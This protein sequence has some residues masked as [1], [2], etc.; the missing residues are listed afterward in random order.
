MVLLPDGPLTTDDIKMLQSSMAMVRGLKGVYVEI[1]SLAG[2]SSVVIGIEAKAQKSRLYCIDVWNSGKWESVAA[3]IGSAAGNYPKRPSNIY[4]QFC[5][6]IRVNYLTD[7]VL[8][9]IERSDVAFKTWSL[10]VRFIF[11]D[12]CHEYGF[13]KKD[14]M[15]GRFLTTGGVI[16][17]HDYHA[18]WPG[19]I[20]AV[21]EVYT[22]NIY[23]QEVLRGVQTIA[24]K[25]VG[26]EGEK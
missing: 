5:D 9:I 10:P 1:G 6:N 7:T 13:V 19:V 17:F 26:T 18:S 21:N 15:W 14:A 20:K 4:Q 23:Y 11:I 2:R 8:T 22:K 3:E 12:G 25:K 16:V 24:F